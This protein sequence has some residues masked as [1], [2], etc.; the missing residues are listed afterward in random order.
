MPVIEPRYKGMYIASPAIQ[1]GGDMLCAGESYEVI[2]EGLRAECVKRGVAVEP[3]LH[4]AKE[5][6]ITDSGRFVSKSAALSMAVWDGQIKRGD[7][8]SPNELAPGDPVDYAA[9]DAAGE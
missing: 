8:A 2:K 6:F 4:D 5:G 1:L 3:A 7:S 9:C